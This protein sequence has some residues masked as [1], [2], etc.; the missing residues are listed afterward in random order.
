MVNF[1]DDRL[2]KSL[3]LNFNSCSV[4]HIYTTTQKPSSLIFFQNRFSI[5]CVFHI[6]PNR[7]QC[8]LRERERERVSLCPCLKH[9]ASHWSG[10]IGL[11]KLVFFFL[12]CGSSTASIY[13][14]GPLTSWNTPA[15]DQDY[16][17]A[18]L[19][20]GETLLAFAL[21]SGLDKPSVF[22]FIF[23]RATDP[24][25]HLHCL[26]TTF[27]LVL[28]IFTINRKINASDTV[29]KVPVRNF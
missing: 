27:C 25:N 20:A 8:F 10:S 11:W 16:S 22:I 7:L 26:M 21:F 19:S 1:P 3:Q 15:S 24:Q 17:A 29:C 5:F 4:N 2:R 9:T 6:H 12:M 14:T 23:S 13:Q 28:R 18:P